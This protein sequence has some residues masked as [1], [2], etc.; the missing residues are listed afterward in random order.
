MI[1]TSKGTKRVIVIL[2]LLLMV[3][4]RIP[5]T[6]ATPLYGGYNGESTAWTEYTIAEVSPALFNLKVTLGVDTDSHAWVRIVFSTIPFITRIEFTYDSLDILSGNFD[7]YIPWPIKIGSQI[8]NNDE[9]TPLLWWFTVYVGFG[10]SGI[11]SERTIWTETGFPGVSGSGKDNNG[12]TWTW[13]KFLNWK[14][15]VGE[16]F[17]EEG[18]EFLNPQQSQELEKVLSSLQ[19]HIDQTYARRVNTLTT[20]L[21]SREVMLTVAEASRKAV[22]PDSDYHITSME[23]TVFTEDVK[24]ELRTLLDSFAQ[25]VQ[26]QLIKLTEKL[27]KTP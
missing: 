26:P 8:E 17:T 22:F 9:I 21:T 4:V 2:T 23:T 6:W 3:L 11:D 18:R 10:V 12:N 24:A 27:K 5:R 14:F 1:H 15:G 16:D 20:L 13:L 19:N 25:D 7:T